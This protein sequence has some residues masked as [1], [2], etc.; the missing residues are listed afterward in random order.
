MIARPIRSGGRLVDE[1]PARLVDED[2]PVNH[3]A[4]ADRPSGWVSRVTTTPG[5]SGSTAALAAAP[6]A[7][8]RRCC[9]G[10]PCCRSPRPAR[11]RPA[12]ARC[13]ARSRPRAAALHAPRRDVP[14]AV[15]AHHRALHPLAAVGDQVHQFGV[16]VQFAVFESA[17][18]G[19]ESP[20][21]RPGR[22]SLAGA[23]PV[24]VERDA[25]L[26]GVGTDFSSRIGTA[27]MWRIP[28]VRAPGA[29]PK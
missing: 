19:E 6:P 13:C 23:E 24:V 4:K 8:P 16:A 9:P 11:R 1:P 20:D 5:P 14:H 2:A 27:T 15:P 17:E 18:R 10:S 3:S 29:A 22:N 26:A 7:G 12:A 25:H 21:Q 28:S